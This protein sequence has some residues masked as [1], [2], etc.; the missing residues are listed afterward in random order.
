MNAFVL[1]SPTHT[2][3]QVIATSIR[4]KIVAV[5]TD[6]KA[7]ITLRK[8]ASADTLSADDNY[9]NDY[10]SEAFRTEVR[11]GPQLHPCINPGLG[12][13]EN[14]V[15]AYI[16]ALCRCLTWTTSNCAVSEL[17]IETTHYREQVEL[18]ACAC[19]WRKEV[20]PQRPNMVTSAYP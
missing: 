9:K 11:G 15:T 19:G 3:T 5:R 1:G 4:S 18:S 20:W 8:C 10:G 17:R 6:E 16:I 2:K 14:S 13:T 12:S 7:E